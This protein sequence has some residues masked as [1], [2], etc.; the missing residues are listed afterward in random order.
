MLKAGLAETILWYR[1]REMP[2]RVLGQLSEHLE[3]P[4]N[5]QGVFAVAQGSSEPHTPRQEKHSVS[6]AVQ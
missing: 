3:L 4:G 5:S 1:R 2:C 6:A